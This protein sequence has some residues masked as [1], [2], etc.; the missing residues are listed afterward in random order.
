MQFDLISGYSA[1]ACWS[2]DVDATVVECYADQFHTVS[3][4]DETEN[5]VV[6][7]NLRPGTCYTLQLTLRDG[8]CLHGEFETCPASA[9]CLENL[10]RSTRREDGVYDTTRFDKATHDVFVSHFSEIVRAGDK[11]L[12]PVSLRGARKDILTKAVTDGTTMDI[13]D[14]SSLFLP[15]SDTRD[16]VQTV[17]LRRDSEETTMAYDASCNSVCYR[18]ASYAVGETMEV[19]GKMVTVGDGSIVLVFSDV[20]AKIFPFSAAVALSVVGTR[21]SSF[22]KNQVANTSSLIASKTTG[23][24]GDTSSSCWVHDTDLSTTD[25]ITRTVHTVDEDSNFATLSMGVLHTDASSNKF[26]EPTIQL[27]STST[28]ISAQDGNDA[29]R[30]ALFESTGLSFDSDESAVYF[31]ASKQFRIKFSDGTP[32]FLQVQ[33]SDGAGGY[34]TKTEFSDST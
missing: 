24:K 14:E 13:V 23:T 22:M 3:K 16:S 26:I 15:F 29:T 30:S 31:G 5:S 20:V 2:A 17:T 27:S 8:S 12:A 21:G 11:I 25:E 34:V 32:S 28:T 4:C 18:G 7:V 19:F 10:Y 6:I 33:S 1:R 9:P